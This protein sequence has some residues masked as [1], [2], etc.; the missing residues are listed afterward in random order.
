[1]P[2][3]HRVATRT[4]AVDRRVAIEHAR[5]V[6]DQMAVGPEGTRDKE[7]RQIRPAPTEQ[8]NATLAVDAEKARQDQGRVHREKRSQRRRIDRHRVGLERPPFHRQGDLARVDNPCGH[9]K[10]Q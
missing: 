4:G 2:R 8:R 1:M 10:A 7:R 9:A 5:Y 6:L 3:N